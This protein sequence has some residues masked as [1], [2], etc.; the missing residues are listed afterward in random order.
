MI[1]MKT[2]NK[3]LPNKKL[4]VW[5]LSKG[6]TLELTHYQNYEEK[7]KDFQKHQL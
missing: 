1:D 2:S 5:V 7:L 6:A 3:I 4:I